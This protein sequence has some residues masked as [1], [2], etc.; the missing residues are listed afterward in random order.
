MYDRR[1]RTYCIC[2]QAGDYVRGDEDDG[3]VFVPVMMTLWGRDEDRASEG[4]ARTRQKRGDEEG[5]SD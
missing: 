5:M 1:S 4:E 3:S 2:I